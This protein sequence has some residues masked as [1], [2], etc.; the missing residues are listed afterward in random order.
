[1]L[2]VYSAIDCHDK[3]AIRTKNNPSHL[4]YVYEHGMKIVHAGPLVCDDGVSPIGTLIIVDASDRE[5]VQ[6]FIDN[7]PYVKAGLFS[8]I[9]LVA[10]SYTHLTLPT[11]PYV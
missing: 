11:T 10:V 7:D 8:Q 6:N 1:M 5:A 4:K 2:F 9:S 3:S